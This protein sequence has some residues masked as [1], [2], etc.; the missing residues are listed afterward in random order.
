MSKYISICYGHRF[1][2]VFIFIGLEGKG[3]LWR[4]WTRDAYNIVVCDD[5]QVVNIGSESCLMF[6]SWYDT[7]SENLPIFHDGVKRRFPKD[8]SDHD[9]PCLEE[10]RRGLISSIFFLECP[11]FPLTNAPNCRLLLPCWTP[12]TATT[13]CTYILQISKTLVTPVNRRN[14]PSLG[15]SLFSLFSLS[16]WIENTTNS[17][18]IHDLHR[19]HRISIPQEKKQ[20][21]CMPICMLLQHPPP[22]SSCYLAPGTF[23]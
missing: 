2:T 6:I 22:P 19:L 23:S 17:A 15:S 7:Y 3:E 12:T 18:V 4:P 11:N 13:R 5:S 1:D 9:A 8:F 14:L 16:L 21:R 10:R 20:D